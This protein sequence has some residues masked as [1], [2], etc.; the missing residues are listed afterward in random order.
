M[1]RRCLL[2]FEGVV[3]NDKAT[4]VK[5]VHAFWKPC[6]LYECCLESNRTTKETY[7]RDCTFWKPLYLHHE[8]PVWSVPYLAPHDNTERLAVIPAL[9]M[10]G[11]GGTVEDG[12]KRN[13][14]SS[15]Y[16]HV[17]NHTGSPFSL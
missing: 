2:P 13:Q 1:L 5:N 3:G 8:G 7:G 16:R 12:L 17:G 11:A 6:L 9:V 4:N 15:S 10:W 14:S